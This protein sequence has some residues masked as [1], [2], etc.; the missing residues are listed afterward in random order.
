MHASR[1]VLCN[2]L[3]IGIVN[4]KH[5]SV[6]MVSVSVC[7]KQAEEIVFMPVVQDA[8]YL[9]VLQLAKS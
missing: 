1:L 6:Y 7:L 2:S 8:R 3:S 4:R 9:E 5:C